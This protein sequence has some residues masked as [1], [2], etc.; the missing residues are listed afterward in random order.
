MQN[1]LFLKADSALNAVEIAAENAVERFVPLGI[2]S[3]FERVSK[4]GIKSERNV[5][6]AERF[7]HRL[8]VLFGK[9][10]DQNDLQA[11]MEGTVIWNKHGGLGL[12]GALASGMEESK[13]FVGIDDGSELFAGEK[14]ALKALRIAFENRSGFVNQFVGGFP[15]G[16]DDW[17]PVE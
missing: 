16:M 13:S 11:V 4:R 14:I 3:A 6:F 12:V 9:N 17:Y 7:L 8:G 10:G 2:G 15:I 1:R 5:E